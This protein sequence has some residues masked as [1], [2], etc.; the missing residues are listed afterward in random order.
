MDT[1]RLLVFCENCGCLTQT[2]EFSNK[3]ALRAAFP[4]AAPIAAD[5]WPGRQAFYAADANLFANVV[6]YDGRQHV[7]GAPGWCYQP[8]DLSL[9][10]I[11]HRCVPHLFATRSNAT[12]APPIPRDVLVVADRA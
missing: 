2:I 5:D 12:I 11:Y 9:R 7:G 10:P 4:N 3:Q 6:S 8:D 1:F